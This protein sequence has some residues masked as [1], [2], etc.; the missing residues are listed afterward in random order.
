MI[1]RVRIAPVKFW[2]EWLEYVPQ[3]AREKIVGKFVTIIPETCSESLECDGKRWLHDLHSVNEMRSLLGLEP[4]DDE[5]NWLC[6]HMLEM[7]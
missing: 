5:D 6:S 1:A 4:K 2:C 3:E 7:D